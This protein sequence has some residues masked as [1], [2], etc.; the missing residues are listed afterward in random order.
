LLGSDFKQRRRP[1]R[2]GV[3]D[4]DIERAEMRGDPVGNAA[5]IVIVADIK[6]ARLNVGPCF[7]REARGI[8]KRVLINMPN[9]KQPRTLSRK[10]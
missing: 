9:Q 4:H 7:T 6:Q 1:D 8:L 5:D 3:V 10:G 2:A